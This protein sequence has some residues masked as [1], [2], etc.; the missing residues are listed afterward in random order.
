MQ[1]GHW[2]SLEH[3]ANNP[4]FVAK[5]DNDG[6]MPLSF[7]LSQTPLRDLEVD[8]DILLSVIRSMSSLSLSPDELGVRIS[9]PVARN[10]IIIRDV[11]KEST[12]TTIREL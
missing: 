4:T 6:Y 2:M 12:E 5:L 8:F 3:L 7:L 10:T 9:L 1:I 11:P